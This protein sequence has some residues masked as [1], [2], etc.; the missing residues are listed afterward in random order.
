[1]TPELWIAEQIRKSGLKICFIAEKIGMDPKILSAIINFHR[2]VRADEFVG[3]CKVIG[4]NAMDYA[5]FV[6]KGDS[7]A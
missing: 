5:P 4:A 1:M 6:L 2:K 3:L 7:N